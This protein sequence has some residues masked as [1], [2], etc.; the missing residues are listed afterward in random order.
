MVTLVPSAS[1]PNVQHAVVL[2][3]QNL[4]TCEGWTNRQH[5]RHMAQVIPTVQHCPV[6]FHDVTHQPGVVSCN[7]CEWAAIN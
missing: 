6:C 5:C 3:P 1:R 4:C 7:H 2:G